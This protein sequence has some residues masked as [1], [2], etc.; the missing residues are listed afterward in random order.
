MKAATAGEMRE[1]DRITIQEYG[2]A[3]RTLM[4]RAGTAVAA[5]ARELFPGKK[6]LVICGGG[7]NGGDGLVAAVELHKSG[8]KVKA[9]MLAGPDALSP[10][11]GAMLRAA[12]KAGVAVEF[13]NS[14]DM[15]DL[16]DVFVIDAVFGTGL[17]RQVEG[18]LAELFRTVNE[19]AAAVLAVD[20]ASGI[21][22]DTGEVLGEAISADY[23]V[24]FGLPKRG[25]FLYPGAGH[26]GRLYVEDI[27]FPAALTDS[28][29][30][31][32]SLFH[33]ETAVGLLPARPRN[34]YKGDYGHILVVA[35]SRGKT[36][37]ALLT[38]GACLRTGSGLVTIAVPE[39]L[40]DIFQAR[41]TEEMVIPLPDKG[42]G[43]LDEEALPVIL[44]FA[45]RR[46][47]VVAFGPGIGVTAATRNIA[48]GL[49]LS[50]AT[51]LVI[52][53]DGLN[54]LDNCMEILGSAKAP[55]II[56]PHPGEMAGL[57]RRR[58]KKTGREETVTTGDV[59]RDRINT[60]LSFSADTGVCTVLKGAPTIIAES[61]GCAYINTS[62]NP[63]MATAGSGDAL[64][65]V[66]A[67]FVG[68]GMT[69]VDAAGLGVYMHGLAG[70]IAVKEKC[71]RSLVASDIVAALPAAF[72]FIGAV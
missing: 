12:E 2:I 64:T 66:I 15:A 6:A 29:D 17:S 1:I 63:G 27:G 13:R 32:T 41:A 54:S 70:D 45:C 28:C 31:K 10:D 34:S 46:A 37:A 23:T 60:A 48:R 3:G 40:M 21:S 18:P 25:H 44:D 69:P 53:A 55:I 59:E 19:S 4:E 58:R 26:T 71:E 5:R 62:G 65:G 39:S 61:G 9:L 35:G 22:S 51:P 57:L 47:D 20:I 50:S 11:C 30:I 16:D 56:T 24:T 49:V 38:A 72:L 68:Q 36:G 7:N 42:D 8:Y 67:S 33:R 14:A 52:D 43:T